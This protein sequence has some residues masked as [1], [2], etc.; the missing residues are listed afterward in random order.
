MLSPRDLRIVG[1]LARQESASIRPISVA[2]ALLPLL[3]KGA[4]VSPL[5][6]YITRDLP[7]SAKGAQRGGR[8]PSVQ[9]SSYDTVRLV[10]EQ[11]DAGWKMLD[12][13]VAI[14]H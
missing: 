11:T 8:H 5:L 9:A 12:V 13:V 1:S 10:A 14:D 4:D 3:T 7:E 6:P 2:G